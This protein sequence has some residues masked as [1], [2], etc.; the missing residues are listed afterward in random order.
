MEYDK[1]YPNIDYE[2]SNVKK[3]LDKYMLPQLLQEVK[4]KKEIYIAKLAHNNQE[5]I[6]ED[7]DEPVIEKKK[8]NTK[9]DEITTLLESIRD[10]KEYKPKFR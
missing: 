3:F 10:Y 9:Q 8:E 1:R 4:E 6:I 2:N 7:I 5:E